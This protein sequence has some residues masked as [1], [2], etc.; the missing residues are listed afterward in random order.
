MPRRWLAW[1]GLAFLLSGSVAAG[2]RPYA[3]LHPAVY[4][5][6]Y[7]VRFCMG[8]CPTGAGTEG[9]GRMG[10]LVLLAAPLRDAR[11]RLGYKYLERGPING[12]LL[13]GP[14]SGPAGYAQFDPDARR[15]RFLVWALEP[16]GR[17]VEFEFNRSPDAGNAMDLHLTPSGLG[18]TGG[19]WVDAGT[20]DTSRALPGNEIQ[21]RRIGEAQ[22][23]RCPRLGEDSE[24]MKD[25]RWPRP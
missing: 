15:R 2:G 20:P 6:T 22:P 18:G 7:A 5:G 8:T 23:A 10:T 3:R 25:V 16:D 19:L 17:T 4:A 1:C 12:C 21:A 14:W 13:L 24:A 11:G 9:V